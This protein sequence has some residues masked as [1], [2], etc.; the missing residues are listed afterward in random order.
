MILKRGKRLFNL[1]F[2]VLLLSTELLNAQSYQLIG[3]YP[4][5]N[6]DKFTPDEVD[7]RRVTQVNHAFVWPEE[8]GEITIP[9]GFINTRLISLAHQAGRKILLS[10]GGATGSYGF[11]AM[12]ADVNTRS[13]FVNKIVQLVEQYHYDGLD[14][15]WEFPQTSADKNN[16]LQLVKD[17][18]SALDAKNPNYLLSMAIPAG[19]W[20]GKWF[21]FKELQNFVDQFNAMTYDYHG[22]WSNHSGHNAPL[23]APENDYCGSVS[24]SIFYLTTV[25]GISKAKLFLGIPFYGRKFTSKGLYQSS[26]GGDLTY[27]YREIIPLLDQGWYFFWDDVSKVPYLRNNTG[28]ELISFDDTLSVK[29]KCEFALKE[30]LAGGMIWA[31]GHDEQN[32]TQPLLGIAARTLAGNTTDLAL[33]SK[34]QP[35]NWQVVVFPNPF[36]SQTNIRLTL[37]QPLVLTLNIYSSTG[38]RVAQLANG[39]FLAGSHIFSWQAKA[40][41]SGIYFLVVECNHWRFIK[42]MVLIK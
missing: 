6:Q 10:V 37:R 12:A 34:L 26:S 42:R 40:L 18:R 27:A 22:G 19:D 11:S 2:L 32:N 17:L 30:K 41:A 28:T 31:L 39:R 13:T 7:F 1:G 3:Y 4:Y 14:I 36:N 9:N 29:L 15:D 33:D 38:E 23:Y 21:P 20:F 8:N 16:I 35:Q 5:W 25:R 24:E